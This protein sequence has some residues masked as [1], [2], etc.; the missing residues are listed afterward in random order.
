MEAV[1]DQ[2]AIGAQSASNFNVN[3][4]PATPVLITGIRYRVNIKHTFSLATGSVTE[5]YEK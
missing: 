1:K 2:H 5:W 3:Y 4:A